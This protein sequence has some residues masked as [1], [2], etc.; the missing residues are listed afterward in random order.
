MFSVIVSAIIRLSI[1]AMIEAP[2]H[3]STCVRIPAGRFLRSR[4]IP[5]TQPMK[6]ANSKRN[7]CSHQDTLSTPNY[8]L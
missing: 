1:M 7:P 6:T 3:T 8:D 5:M 4:S 2:T